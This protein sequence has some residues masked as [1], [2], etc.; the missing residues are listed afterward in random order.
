MVSFLAWIF[1]F[2]RQSLPSLCGSYL[3]SKSASVR[4]SLG[5]K[6]LVVCQGHS[7]RSFAAFQ[8]SCFQE[9]REKMWNVVVKVSFHNTTG[10][11]QV[12][13]A[14]HTSCKTRLF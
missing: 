12:C 14:L 5:S 8:L 13:K 1:L 7:I 6:C 10:N 3:Q 11:S 9:T 2:Q 4:S